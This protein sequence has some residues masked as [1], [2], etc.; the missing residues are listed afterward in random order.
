MYQSNRLSDR[1]LLYKILV[2]GLIL[3]ISN[4]YNIHEPYP[5]Y[6]NTRSTQ[7]KF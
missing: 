4:C 5:L 1:H 2:D 6:S 7:L 3:S